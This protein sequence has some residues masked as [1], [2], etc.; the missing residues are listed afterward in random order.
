MEVGVPNDEVLT[1]V[2]G[3]GV[4]EAPVPAPAVEGVDVPVAE[5]PVTGEVPVL[6]VTD[7]VA[8]AKVPFGFL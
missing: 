1:A 5:V 7:A 4:E 8:A 2:D 3:G 6:A